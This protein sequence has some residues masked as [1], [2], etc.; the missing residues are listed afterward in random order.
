MEFFNYLNAICVAYYIILVSNYR[1]DSIAIG[2]TNLLLTISLLNIGRCVI[3][4]E[5]LVDRVEKM[6]K[7]RILMVDFACFIF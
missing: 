6:N 7:C 1:V 2:A 4:G 3:V 5:L